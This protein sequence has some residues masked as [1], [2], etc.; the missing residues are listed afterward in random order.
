MMLDL[1]RFRQRFAPRWLIM[2]I[3]TCIVLASLALAYALRFDFAIPDVEGELLQTS[4]FLFLAV[5]L[6]GLLIS[7]TYAG[8]IRYTSTQDAARILRVCLISTLVLLAAGQLRYFIFDQVYFLPTSIIILEFFLTTFLLITFRL[9]VKLLYSEQ[10]NPRK[11]KKKVILYGAGES[12]VITKRTLDRDAGSAME[13]VAFIDDDPRKAGKKLEGVTIYKSERLE[14]LI[15]DHEVDQ[16]ISTMM[17]PDIEKRQKVIDLCIDKGVKVLDVPPVGRWIQGELSFRQLRPIPVEDLLERSVI[18]LDTSAISQSLQGK[19]IMVTG[20]AGSIGS[21]LVRQ[22]TRYRPEAIC[23]LDQAESPLHEISLEVTDSTEQEIV[24]TVLADICHREHLQRIFKEFRPEIVFHAA[25][26]KHVPMVESNAYEGI[27]TNLGGTRNLVDLA[28]ENKVDRFVMIST[29]KAVNPTNVMGA[30]KRAA[31][32]YV[33][34]LSEDSSTRFVTTRFGNVLGSNGSVIPRFKKQI[35][36]GGPVTVTHPDIERFFMTIPEACQL[37]L[38]A[39]AMGKGGEIFVF[40]MGKA[41]R[42]VDLAH[43]MIRLSGLEVG[44]DIE[45]EM[46]GLRPG[47]KIKEEVLADKENTLPTHNER[48]LIAK[49]RDIPTD[50]IERIT[51]LLDDSDS[52]LESSVKKLKDLIPEYRSHNSKFEALDR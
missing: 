6:G 46:T 9:V 20:A 15:D 50:T 45:V 7:R 43:K 12:G 23:L 27:R 51:S 17:R 31:E 14:E 5:R 26:Y 24:L 40:D 33:S 42:I 30:S 35:E 48:I 3:D 37:V 38:E 19:R 18:Q 49:T 1:D 39:G 44:K 34:A 10:K 28:I 8:V 52:D 21:E 36:D 29:D 25:A 2:L 13:V 22:I 4:I 32:M 47:E 41:V 16:L 11:L